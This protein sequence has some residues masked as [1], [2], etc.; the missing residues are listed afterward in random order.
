M[1]QKY[2]KL[3]KEKGVVTSVVCKELDLDPSSISHWKKGN[4]TPKADKILKIADYFGVSMDYFY[5]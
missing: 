2:E 3:C 5:R 1:Y 4:F